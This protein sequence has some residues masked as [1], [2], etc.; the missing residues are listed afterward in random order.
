MNYSE[1]VHSVNIL[2]AILI[3]GVIYYIYYIFKYDDLN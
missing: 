3:G 1:V 2:I